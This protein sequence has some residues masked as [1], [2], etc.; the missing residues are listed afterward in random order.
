MMIMNKGLLALKYDKL[1]PKYIPIR[2]A[3]RN[4]ECIYVIIFV[5]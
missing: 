2:S 5:N 1:E 4:K 3:E